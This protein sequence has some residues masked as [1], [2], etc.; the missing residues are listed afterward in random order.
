[1]SMRD[2]PA[3]ATRHRP[4]SRL[5]AA[6]LAALL[7]AGCVLYEDRED[8]DAERTS[9]GAVREVPL[10]VV[11]QG[12]R[13]LAFVPVSIEGEGPF[14]FALDTGAS[15][16]VVDEDVADR[17][18]L[19]RTGERRSVSG[20]LGTGQVPVA[21]VDQWRVGDVPID[22]GEVTVIDLGPPRGGGGIQGLL[23]SDVLSDYRSITVDYEDGVLEIPAL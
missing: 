12:D 4:A 6:P 5:V 16:S 10:R 14:M 22:P 11:E 17:V 13:T 9:P 21:R 18:G 8:A 15:T 3:P 2:A 7:L 1:M 23:G 20:I 19:E